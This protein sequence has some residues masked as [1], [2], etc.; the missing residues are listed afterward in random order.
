MPALRNHR[1]E[2]FAQTIV[3]NARNGINLTDAYRRSGYKGTGHTAEVGGSRLM[4]YAEVQMRI[5]ELTAPAVRKT[6]RNLE[7][8]F[9]EV[10]KVLRDAEADK[11]HH[12]RLQ[13]LALILRIHELVLEHAEPEIEIGGGAKTAAEIQDMLVTQIVD[14]LGVDAAVGIADAIVA[15]IA[16]QAIPVSV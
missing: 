15:R 14:E 6:G 3:R 5:A 7:A 12:V 13:A 8:L 10:E 11:L 1:R 4:S 9:I 16:D 2:L